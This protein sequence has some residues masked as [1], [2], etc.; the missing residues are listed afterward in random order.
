[1]KMWRIGREVQM[2][3]SFLYVSAS[4]RPY[5]LSCAYKPS[6][7]PDWPFLFYSGY[8]YRHEL[9]ELAARSQRHHPVPPR[10]DIPTT[11]H[12]Q[13]YQSRR[14]SV[15]PKFLLPLRFGGICQLGLVPQPRAQSH[16][17][18][19]CY[20]F[21][22]MGPQIP[23]DNSTKSRT[24]CP[25]PYPR[26]LFPRGAQVP[27][28]RARPDAA[29]PSSLIRAPVLRRTRRLC[30]PRQSHC[31]PYHPRNRRVLHLLVYLSHSNAAHLS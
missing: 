18:A 8:F 22:T 23:P 20:T 13:R 10:T 25:C 12:Y 17:R 31:R 28:L 5:R 26:V 29:F 6:R 15:Y 7:F 21:A 2:A 16:M 4:H 24:S 1:M 9:P 3:S 30:L 19:H 11:F 14:E 27:H